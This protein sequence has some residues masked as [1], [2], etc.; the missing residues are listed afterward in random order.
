M[1]LACVTGYFLGYSLLGLWASTVVNIPA[2]H[3]GGIT[4]PARSSVQPF[5][6]ISLW[7]FV[8][9]LPT[10]LT[11]ACFHRRVRAVAPLVLG[12]VTTV[13]TGTWFALVHFSGPTDRS[14]FSWVET[15]GDTYSEW[16][17]FAI[18]ILLLMSLIAVG[19]TLV[20]WIAQAYRKRK[21]SDRSLLL[22]A[23]WLVFAC[24]YSM[25][26]VMG[27]LGWIVTAPA[28]FLIY[29]VVLAAGNKFAGNQQKASRGLTFLRVFSLGSRS[30][31]LLED[32]AKYWRNIGSVQMITGPDVASSTVQPHQFLDFLS[33]KLSRHFVGD[34]A[35]LERSLAE[36]DFEQDPDGRFRINSL[37]FSRRLV[38]TSIATSCWRR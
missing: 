1:W 35:S 14:S 37:F 34:P 7:I 27:G 36:R 32:L 5:N 19:W 18:L 24:T 9:A 10:I 12:L 23:L 20:F 2:M 26:L 3:V 4:L 29:K 13:V 6:M 17:M 22:D 30:E 16:L 11:I 33:G 38:A 8:N 15:L 28:G 31:T 25:W 21:L